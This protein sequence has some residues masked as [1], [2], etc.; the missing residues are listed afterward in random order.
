MSQ[1][2][3]SWLNAYEARNRKTPVASGG[4]EDEGE[5][6]AEVILECKKRGWLVFHGSMAHKTFRT[7][8]EP[9]LLICADKG[10]FYMIELK[11]RAGKLS[12]DQQAIAAW[13]SR[14]GH[15]VFVCRSLEQF[16]HV[17]DGEKP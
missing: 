15:T 9:D 14:L 8:G 16:L 1:F 3:T 17:I 5:L 2:D 4:V 7:P 10:R 11:T 13:A 6:H 12:T